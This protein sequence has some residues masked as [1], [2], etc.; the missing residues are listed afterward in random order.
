MNL[1]IGA[2]LLVIAYCFAGRADIKT[3]KGLSN[4]YD[5]V[6]AYGLMIVG[7]VMILSCFGNGCLLGD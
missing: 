1:I 5:L 6:L 4:T 2:L 3:T 7:S